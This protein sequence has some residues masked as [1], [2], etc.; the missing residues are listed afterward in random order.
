MITRKEI[1]LLTGCTINQ[2][3]H[4]MKMHDDVP[5]PVCKR[6]HGTLFF[7]KKEML[8]WIEKHNVKEIYLRQYNKQPEVQDPFDNELAQQFIRRK[9]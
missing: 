9:A 8:A 1:V 6:H 2:L 3:N 4:A 5:K 7:D